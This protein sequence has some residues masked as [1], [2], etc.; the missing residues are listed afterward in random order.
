[1]LTKQIMIFGGRDERRLLIESNASF[2]VR[3]VAARSPAVIIY[4][5]L[6]VLANTCAQMRERE[7]ERIVCCVSALTGREPHL[8]RG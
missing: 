7:R 1:M 3:L 8:F 4:G 2:V 6:L 5:N